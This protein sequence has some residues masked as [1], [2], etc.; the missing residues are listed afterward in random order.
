MNECEIHYYLFSYSKMLSVF[1]EI[2]LLSCEDR[3]VT[4]KENLK[5]LKKL[6]TISLYI[7]SQTYKFHLVYRVLQ[8]I[9]M[10]FFSIFLSL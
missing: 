2:K 10:I 5:I 9:L 6:H 1:L 7:Y 8:E 4:Q 3:L